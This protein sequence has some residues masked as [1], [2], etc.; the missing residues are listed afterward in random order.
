MEL[1]IFY[2]CIKLKGRVWV[3]AEKTDLRPRWV[4]WCTWCCRS[5]N[6]HMKCFYICTLEINSSFFVFSFKDDVAIEFGMFLIVV[7]SQPFKLLILQ[8]NRSFSN[9]DLCQCFPIVLTVE[10]IEGTAVFLYD[11]SLSLFKCWKRVL[12]LVI[13]LNY[14]LVKVFTPL[15]HSSLFFLFQAKSPIRPSLFH[16]LTF[17]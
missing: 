6:F 3:W 12:L 1:R 10:E 4:H 11:E 16:Q 7:S 17:L 15:I 5:T 13:F 8:T 2:K 14:S 9:C